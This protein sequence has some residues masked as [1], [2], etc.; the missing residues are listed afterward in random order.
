MIRHIRWV[1]DD[2]VRTQRIFVEWGAALV[3]AYVALGAHVDASS[4]LSTW[5]LS[6]FALALYTTSVI[7]DMADHPISLTR[8]L[9][10]PTRGHYIG[11]YLLAALLVVLSAYA[12][13]VGATAIVAPNAFPAWTVWLASIPPLLV[14]ICTGVVVMTMLTP[15]VASPFQRI[16]LLAMLAV[17]L[18]WDRVIAL[19]PDML[20]GTVMAIFHALTT[21][22]GVIL[23]P[24]MQLY[25]LC[26]VPQYTVVS[27]LLATIHIGIVTGLAA[28]TLRWYV[29]RPLTIA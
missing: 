2:Y 18:A 5:A 24:S 4:T 21:V 8:L 11:A 7:A 14:L 28:L 17:P 3:V 9:Q 26:I 23:W 12:I 6:A 22:F 19:L 20:P 25:A 16:F 1:L 15:L 10:L 27:I 13:L 29:R